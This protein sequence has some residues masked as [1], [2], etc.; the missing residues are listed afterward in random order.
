[1]FVL[2][3]CDV[4]IAGVVT[5]PVGEPVAGAELSDGDCR[6]VSGADGSFLTRCARDSYA[7]V[8]RHPTHAAAEALVD[9]TGAMSPPPVAVQLTPWPA[10]PGL[11]LEPA[12]RPLEPLALHRTAATDEQRFCVDL[13]RVPEASGPVSI[14]D[15]H[16]V[17]WRVYALD[18][19]GCALR[20]S[21]APGT[22]WWQP[23]GTRV[24]EKG[25]EAL[26][27]GRERVQFELEPG[28][29][30]ALAW[31]D[32]FLVPLEASD[33]TW[34]GWALAAPGA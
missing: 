23:Q 22:S 32:G 12:L 30:V 33:D 10:T 3:A 15:V 2:V 25:R 4:E 11:Y 28:R 7:F 17:D 27:T 21:R 9:A 13:A 29:Y 19:E 5:T 26:A 34:V 18:A 6:A 20:L 14:F 1:M 16:A 8:V 31:Y 24:T